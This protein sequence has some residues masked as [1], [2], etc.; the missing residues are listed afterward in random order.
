MSSNEEVKG[1]NDTSK[2][3]LE[4]LKTITKAILLLGTTLGGKIDGLGDKIDD[5]GEKVTQ[6]FHDLKQDINSL[7]EE[8]KVGDFSLGENIKAL[9]LKLNQ[10]ISSKGS[11]EYD[12]LFPAEVPLGEIKEDVKEEDVKEEDVEED[13]KNNQSDTQQDTNVSGG[14]GL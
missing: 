6:G 3:M 10:T 9:E 2:Q 1:G 4:E 8:I 12:G 5:L 7:K 13:A 11:F 14:D